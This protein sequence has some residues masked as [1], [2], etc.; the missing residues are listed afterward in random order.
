MNI[1]TQTIKVAPLERYLEL[2]FKNTMLCCSH[3]CALANQRTVFFSEALEK[4][5]L[6][7]LTD[8]YILYWQLYI[9]CYIVSSAGSMPV[10]TTVNL[11]SEL[12]TPTVTVTGHQGTCMHPVSLWEAI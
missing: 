6:T 2:S 8:Q 3:A 12:L 5:V 11:P 7:S 10:M 9:S 1:Y 4:F